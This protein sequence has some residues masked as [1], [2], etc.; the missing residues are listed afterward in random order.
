MSIPL[1][2]QGKFTEKLFQEAS[3]SQNL[4]SAVIWAVFAPPTLR[5]NSIDKKRQEAAPYRGFIETNLQV[6]Q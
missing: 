4:V 2:F 6:L 3:P 5:S 1:V